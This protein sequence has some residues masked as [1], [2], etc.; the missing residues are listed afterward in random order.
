MNESETLIFLVFCSVVLWSMTWF[1][2]PDKD[3]PFDL[4][5]LN[6]LY[7]YAYMIYLTDRDTVSH[8]MYQMRNARELEDL[9]FV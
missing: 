3:D 5:T 9:G 8:R 1:L 2:Q 7:V 6:R 4:S